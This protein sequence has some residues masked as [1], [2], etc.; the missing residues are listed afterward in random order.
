MRLPAERS[1]YRQAKIMKH[2]STGT[3][4]A[5]L[6]KRVYVQHEKKPV[7][8]LRSIHSVVFDQASTKF[9]DIFVPSE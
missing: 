2:A 9:I 6:T 4:Y 3:N 5:I 1:K 8:N 7:P